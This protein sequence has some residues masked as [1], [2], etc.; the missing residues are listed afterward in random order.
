MKPSTGVQTKQSWKNNFSLSPREVERDGISQQFS[1]DA[2]QHRNL[3]E[4]LGDFGTV[5]G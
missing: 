5:S 3:S 4:K 2:H 1:V